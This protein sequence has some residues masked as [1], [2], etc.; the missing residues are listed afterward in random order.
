VRYNRGE[1]EGQTERRNEKNFNVERK[2]G[3]G[4]EGRK[5]VTQSVT[6]ICLLDVLM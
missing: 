6:G 3:R 2:V 1:G 4:G 5:T